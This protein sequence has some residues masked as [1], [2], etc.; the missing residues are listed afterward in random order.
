MYEKIQ[1]GTPSSHTVAIALEIAKKL[2]KRIPSPELQEA[3]THIEA[4]IALP[5][6]ELSSRTIGPSEPVVEEQ[7]SDRAVEVL[8][9]GFNILKEGAAAQLSVIGEWKNWC[10]KRI[11]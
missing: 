4:Q 6:K 8:S 10:C 2:Q 1:K 5:S 11:Q 7:P 3:R 9:Q